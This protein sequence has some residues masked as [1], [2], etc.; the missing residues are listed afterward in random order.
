TFLCDYYDFDGNFVSM[1]EYGD[2]LTIGSTA[3]VVSY[4]DIGEN[5][6]LVC[7]RLTDI[8]RNMFYTQS[9]EFTFE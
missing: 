8:Y 1:Y 3:P 7:F 6:T 4:E 2:V 5:K 9:V